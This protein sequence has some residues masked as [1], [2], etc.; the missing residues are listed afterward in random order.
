M[1]HITAEQFKQAMGSFP[2][3]VTIVTARRPDGGLHGVTVSSFAALS[4]TPRL[5]SFAINQDGDS[6][7]VLSAATHFAIHILGEGQEALSSHFA[8]QGQVWDGIGHSL[9]SAGLPVFAGT[10]ARLSC[11]KVAQ[12]TPTHHPVG[13]H[14]ILIGELMAVATDPTRRPL[15]Y[16]RGDY[17]T[18]AR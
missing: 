18:L 4:L 8:R 15:L 9:D 2:S 16:F 7:T 10:V 13:D 3:G 5:V 12:I 6:H 14:D 11:R 1:H 17:G